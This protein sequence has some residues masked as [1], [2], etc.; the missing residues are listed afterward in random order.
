MCR[1]WQLSAPLSL[2]LSSQRRLLFDFGRRAGGMRSVCF[3]LWRFT[4]ALIS[5]CPLWVDRMSA[6][7]QKA[8]YGG[9]HVMSAWLVI[10]EPFGVAPS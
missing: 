6:T 3:S 2:Y 4:V 9:S 10:P 1:R 5:E 7:G 8:K